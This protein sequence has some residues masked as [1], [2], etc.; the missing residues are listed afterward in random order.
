MDKS[1]QKNVLVAGF[2]DLDEAERAIKSGKMQ[3]TINQQAD[4]QGYTGVKYAYDMLGGTKEPPETIV[5]V[6]VVTSSN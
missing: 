2:D 6:K 1:N 5:D 3:V 4:I